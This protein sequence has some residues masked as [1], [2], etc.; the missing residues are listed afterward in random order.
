MKRQ[1]LGIDIGTSACKVAVFGE[2]GDVLASPISHIRYITRKKAGRS[3]M[4]MSGGKPSAMAYM[5][6]F[7]RRVSVRT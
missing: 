1:L 4:Q 6:C 3:R 7:G 2:D 5:K